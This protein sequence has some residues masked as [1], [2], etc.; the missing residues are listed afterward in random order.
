MITEQTK[1]EIE[2]DIDA[3]SRIGA[4]SNHVAEAENAID[5]LSPDIVKNRIQGFDIAVNVAQNGD[6][7][8]VGHGRNH[9]RIKLTA[10]AAKTAEPSLAEEGWL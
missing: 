3:L 7:L 1:L 9:W 6:A 8:V 4:V 10:K 2:A 5:S